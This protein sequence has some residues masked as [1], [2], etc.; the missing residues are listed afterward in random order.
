MEVVPGL[1]VP[2]CLYCFALEVS[3]KNKAVFLEE[4]VPQ[5]SQSQLWRP[6]CLHQD[7]QNLRCREH[8][9]AWTDDVLHFW[10]PPLDFTAVRQ[11]KAHVVWFCPWD[12]F[13]LQ[14]NLQNSGSIF[15]HFKNSVWNP[16][17]GYFN[18]L[19]WSPAHFLSFSDVQQVGIFQGCFWY[20]P[21]ITITDLRDPMGS[22]W[23]GSFFSRY[24]WGIL[25][26]GQ[27]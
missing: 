24:C 3:S 10:L 18:T 12:C 4:A 23:A 21:D 14:W 2:Q 8:E 25:G 16:E 6:C 13:P 17:N 20:K 22:P 11:V 27:P 19:V 7:S 1:E 9:G 5:Q 15:S 26:E